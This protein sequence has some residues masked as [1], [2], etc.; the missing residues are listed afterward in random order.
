MI[1]L[2]GM[3]VVVVALVVVLVF[4]WWCLKKERADLAWRTAAL[5]RHRQEMAKGD[6][7]SCLAAIVV[8][9]RSPKE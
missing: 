3:G 9:D 5:M 1:D 8:F 4:K 6:R 2:I 7:E